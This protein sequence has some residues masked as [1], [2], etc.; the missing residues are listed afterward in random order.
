MALVTTEGAE[1]RSHRVHRYRV[2]YPIARPRVDRRVF[3]RRPVREAE[4]EGGDVMRA[5]TKAEN[6]ALDTLL[7]LRHPTS[8]ANLGALMWGRSG[9]GNCSCPWARPAGAVLARLR[10]LPVPLVER[11]PA[12]GRTDLYALTDVGVVFARPAAASRAEVKRRMEVTRG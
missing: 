1:H 5:L 9:F 7:R 12:P 10:K 11:V 6:L 8:A 4:A 2:Q 3:Q